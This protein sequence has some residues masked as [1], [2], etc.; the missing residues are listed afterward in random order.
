MTATNPNL[1]EDVVA[2]LTESVSEVLNT[3]FSIEA[4]RAPD[5]I[6]PAT[7]EPFVVGSVGFTGEANGVV[8]LHVSV[9][10]ARQLTSRMLGLT[11]AE[12]EG[13]EMVN[14]V[15]GELSNMIVGAV[16]SRLCDSGLPCLLTI[17]T[18]VRG[19]ALVAEATRNCERREMSFHCGSDVLCVELLLKST[20]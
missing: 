8:Y 7:G 16:K 11:E 1:I 13:D 2:M 6:V 12:I 9:P 4:R 14:D 18:I 3:M 20:K 10:F 15:I 5:G 17:P 19:T